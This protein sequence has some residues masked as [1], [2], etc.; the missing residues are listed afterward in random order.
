MEEPL[1]IEGIPADPRCWFFQMLTASGPSSV[2]ASRAKENHGSLSRTKPQKIF[3]LSRFPTA[4]GHHDR[5][6]PI[7]HKWTVD[8]GYRDRL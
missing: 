4:D 6:L 1:H 5:T 2:G 8:R 7:D 3:Y